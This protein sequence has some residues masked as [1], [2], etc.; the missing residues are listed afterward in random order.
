[1]RKIFQLLCVVML[2]AFT[3]PALADPAPPNGATKEEAV[4]FVKK[5]VEYFKVSGS[6]KAFAEF[7]NTHG[8]FTDRDLYIFVIDAKGICLAHGRYN[9]LVG[10]DR[11]EQ[12]DADGVFYIK[13][14]TRLM[15]TNPTFWTHYKYPDP[16]THVITPKSSYCE[17]ASDPVVKD[18]AICSGVYDAKP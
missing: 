18:V 13:D 14:I 4:A 1:M 7:N 5:A 16:L 17:V 12:Q 9:R 8:A 10:Q 15:K 3:Q 11:N 6:A 2:T